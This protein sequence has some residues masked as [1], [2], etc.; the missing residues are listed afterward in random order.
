MSLSGHPSGMIVTLHTQAISTLDQVRAFLDGAADVAFTPVDSSDRHAWL[1]AM[2]RQFGYRQRSRADKGLL[3]A[4]AGK[5]TGYS[6]A[7]VARLLA[8]WCQHGSL[9]DR[10]GPPAKAFTRRYTDEDVRLLAEIDRLHD[11]LSG[12]A[13][14]MIAQRMHRTFGEAAYERLAGISIAHLYNL[15]ASAGYQRLRGHHEP[16]RA[17]QIAIGERRCPQPNGRPGY[18]RVDSVH[19]GD[20]DGVKGLYAINLVDAVT[21]YQLVLA[22]ERIS[23]AFLLP[24]LEQALHDFPFVIHGFHS[25]NGSEYVNHRV[26]RMLD[27][28]HIEFTK[29]RPR[30]SND[31]ALAES[32]NAS[33]VRKHLGYAHIPGRQ[34]PKVNAFLRDHLNPYINFHR[35]CFF[36]TTTT[37]TKGR[38]RKRYRPDDLRTPYE[39]L[40]QLPDADA[41]LKPG[42]TFAQLDLIAMRQTDN[43]AAE[44][45]Q[46]ARNQLFQT[47]RGH[48]AA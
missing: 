16:T 32:K 23:E 34:A 39:H 47:L 44:H 35:P 36:P 30:R 8:Q 41:F 22:V 40:K 10:R 46:H 6:R 3:R 42:M 27:K 48:R 17:R 37:D 28:L 24:A 15:R 2:L 31:N 7:Q 11:Q 12:P 29:S 14:R 43:Q 1:A 13:T 45:M 38:Q 20:W 19:Q 21:Q 5:V 26:A 33:V 4:Y 18:L 25:D 9:R